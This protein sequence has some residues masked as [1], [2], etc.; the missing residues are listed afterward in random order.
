MLINQAQAAETVEAAADSVAEISAQTGHAVSAHEVFY[1]H[2]TFWVAIAFF[3]FFAIFGKKLV[4]AIGAILDDRAQ[5]ISNEI[6]TATRMREEAQELLASYEKKQ[7]DALKEAQN[8]VEA[9]KDEAERLAAEAGVNL[10]KS[11]KR[12]EQLAIDRIHQAEIQALA[13]VKDQAVELAIDAARRI[14]ESDISDKKADALIDHATKDL[15][16]LH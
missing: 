6:E 11:L 13:Q 16:K 1:E 2:P 12:A 10:E 9:A 5:R 7:H 8:I 4:I 3:I 15:E 14:L